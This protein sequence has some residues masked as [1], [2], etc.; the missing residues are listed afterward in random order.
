MI[1]IEIPYNVNEYA[2]TDAHKL[3]GTCRGYLFD[4]RS[5]TVLGRMLRRSVKQAQKIRRDSLSNTN[6]V[7]ILEVIKSDYGVSLGRSFLHDTR[8]LIGLIGEILVENLFQNSS[9]TATIV[10]WKITGTSKSKGIDLMCRVASERPPDTLLLVESKH[11]HEEAKGTNVLAPSILAE[12]LKRG[13]SEFEEEKTLLDLANTVAKLDRS[14]AIDRSIS[15]DPQEK[16]VLREF[17]ADRLSDQAYSV[18]IVV[19]IDNR[20][21]DVAL[22]RNAARLV[23]EP[24]WIVKRTISFAVVTFHR[25]EQETDKLCERFARQ[26]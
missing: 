24:S 16:R 5:E 19:S 2:P 14:I 26:D 20:F 21:S 23:Q 17:I 9:V 6:A 22:A 15:S 1:S 13:L 3:W 8:D 12:K 4:W 11:V 7:R 10:K 25:L 18:A